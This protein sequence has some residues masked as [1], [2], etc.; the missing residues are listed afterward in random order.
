MKIPDAV[1]DKV[2]ETYLCYVDVDASMVDNR[3]KM[4][5]E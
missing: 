4:V 1:I 5:L 3:A 2:G